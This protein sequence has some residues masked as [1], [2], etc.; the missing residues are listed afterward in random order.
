M[1]LK[2]KTFQKSILILFS[3]LFSVNAYSVD[4]VTLHNQRMSDNKA[5]HNFTVI[6]RALE[7]TEE[8]Y[9]PF[10]IGMVSK[11][12]PNAHLHKAVLEGET[13]NT[14]IVLAN[15]MWDETTIGIKVPVRLGLLSYRLLLVN[16]SNLESFEQVKKIAELRNFYAGLVRG[17]Q[18]TKVF[19]FLK[20]NVKVVGNFE[21]IYLMLDKNRFDYIPRGIY[22][23]YDELNSRKGRYKNVVVEPNIAL[24]IPTISR[25]YVSPKHPRIAKRLDAGLHKIIASG[26]LKEILFK[27]YEKDIQRADISNRRVISIENPYYDKT[28]NLIYEKLLIEL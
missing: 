24:K 8:E 6:K 16:K 26:E 2:T 1:F 5:A 17:W 28:E 27:F 11:P 22:E 21:G 15:D 12:M 9:G 10:E 23:I 18:T 19:G 14:I 25:V 3:I 20:L 7:V 13:F 4:I